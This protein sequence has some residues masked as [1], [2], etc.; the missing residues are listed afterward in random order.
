MANWNPWHGCHKISAGCLNCYVYRMD[1]EYDKDASVVTKNSTFDLPIKKNKKGEY[2]IPSGEVVNTCFS[3]DFFVPDADE[4]RKDAWKMMKERSD[5]TFLFLTKRI[6]R[7]DDVIPDDWEDGYDNV[8]IICTVE[9]QEMADYRLPL[10]KKAKI[11][12]K[13]IACAPLLSDIDLEKYL[14]ETIDEVDASGE[15]GPGARV[16]DYDWV[17]HIREQCI[18]KGVGFF[19]HQT[20]ANFKKDG[21]IYNIKRKDQFTQTR[22][23]NIN[24]KERNYV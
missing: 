6:D 4:W 9:N 24:T 15:S 22:K 23:A 5:L 11:K 2:K 12:H 1:K 13:G 7:F 18:N 17:L 3:S 14:D 21:K 16:C 20:G 8:V 19:F 10:Y